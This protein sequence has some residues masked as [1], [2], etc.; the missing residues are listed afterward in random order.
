MK[1]QLFTKDK[2]ISDLEHKI[3]ELDRELSMS[4]ILNL[5]KNELNNSV[6]HEQTRN[7]LNSLN[8]M[9][10]DSESRLSRI[11]NEKFVLEQKLNQLVEI[12][13]NQSIELKVRNQF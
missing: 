13:K 12:I 10:E 6:H 7:K 8:R 9:L 4:K 3:K 2:I 5:D 11:N 1:S